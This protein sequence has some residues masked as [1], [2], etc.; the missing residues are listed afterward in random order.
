MALPLLLKN[1]HVLDPQ[2]GVILEREDIVIDDGIITN[3]DQ[4]IPGKIQEINLDK[5]IVVPGGIYSSFRAPLYHQDAIDTIPTQDMAKML[6]QSGF[7]TV[8]VEGY[9]PFTALDNHWFLKKMPWINKVPV[10]DV[11]NFQF[12]LNFLKN[13]IMNYARE[14]M[15]I[16]LE[17]FGGYGISCL[18]PGVASRWKQ[19]TLSAEYL[20]EN[21]PFIRIPPEKLIL[22][23]VKVQTKNVLKPGLFL[24]LGIEGIPSAYHSFED[25][26]GKINEL[27]EG[28]AN[29]YANSIILKQIS[30]LSHHSSLTG[31]FTLLEKT[32]F[33][34]GM[35]DLPAID[36]DIHY[37]NFHPSPLQDVDDLSIRGTIEGEIHHAYYAVRNQ[38]KKELLHRYWLSGQDFIIHLPDSMKH[39]FAFSIMPMVLEKRICLNGP[40]CSLLSSE[41]RLNHAKI[42]GGEDLLSRA[43]DT[44]HDEVL[45]LERFVNITRAVPAKFLGLEHYMGGLKNGQLGDAIILDFAPEDWEGIRAEPK[46]VVKKILDPFMIVKKGDIV[47]KNG[48]FTSPYQGITFTRTIPPNTS[49]HETVIGNLEKQFL[50]F[51]STH[52]TSKELP[53]G[54]LGET[55]NVQE[56]DI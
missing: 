51:Y 15:S 35:V 10:V 52:L 25:I 34:S 56:K 40:I 17:K 50:K 42:N 6:L 55:I 24:E 47:Y 46:A 3:L 12:M 38:A 30:S 21:I 20:H 22:E 41:F 2:N 27:C 5:R 19:E 16:L 49:I 13:G 32:P 45:S 1:G 39:R 33:I 31:L 36:N 8:V 48:E 26:I 11:A 23:L 54:F 14:T 53:E 29:S 28:N 43:R 4:E 18:V 44:L 9:T 37:I 7:T